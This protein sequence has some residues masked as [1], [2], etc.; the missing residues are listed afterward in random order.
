MTNALPR[1]S[2]IRFIVFLGTVSLFADITYEG[3]RSVIGPYFVQL[4]SSAAI[5][6]VVSGAGELAGF[7]LRLGSGYLADR[8]RAYWLL[9][10]IGYG[11]NML[12]VPLMA[13]AGNWGAAA[14]LVIAERTGK[15]IRTPAR[16]V[17]LSQA[18]H[19]VGRGWGFGLHAAM[20]QVGAVTGPLLVAFVL[21]RTH[22]FPTA[23]KILAIPAALA[24]ATLLLARANYPHPHELEPAGKPLTTR[25]Y[26]RE[27][28]LYVAAAGML[29]AGFVD[30]P[31]VAYHL[32]K[33]AI[34][35]AA[36]IP[37]IYALAMAVNAVGALAFGKLFDRFGVLVLP[38]G[39]T[40]STIGLPLSFYGSFAWALTGMALW[41]AA[42]G[43][44]D[45]ALR[46]GIAMMIP[47]DQRGAA[48]GVYNAV[49]G[50]AWF[51]G[52]AIM[53]KLYDLSMMG[54]VGFGMAAQFASCVLFL[55]Y[56]RTRVHHS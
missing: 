53:G 56:R 7:T 11:M 14:A 5:V 1:A 16:D 30:F 55:L 26:S 45:A 40:M 32:Q 9:T 31:L 18:T 42:M 25:G 19:T 51:L 41:G 36:W 15:S 54:L 2:A 10:I 3:A 44:M 43:A 20:D 46:A 13:F 17:M 24:M 35:P 28:W 33:Q 23:F 39:I 52:S 48:Y 22:S 21:S 37:L 47:R 8:T 34:A 27:F 49:F 29:A 12:A 50:V 38:I 6:G 4:G